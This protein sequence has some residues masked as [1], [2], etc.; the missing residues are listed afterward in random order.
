MFLARK[1]STMGSDPTI[2]W[3]QRG[4]QVTKVGGDGAQERKWVLELLP[5]YPVTS[6]GGGGEQVGT[7]SHTPH[8]RCRTGLPELLPEVLWAF[9][10]SLT[11]SLTHSSTRSAHREPGIVLS[12]GDTGENITKSLRYGCCIA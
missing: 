4:A 10:R 2:P 5:C 12:A 8:P 3:G 9:T 6:K 11:H 1:V 7:C